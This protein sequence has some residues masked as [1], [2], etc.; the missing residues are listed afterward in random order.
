MSGSEELMVGTPS[1]FLHSILDALPEAI[2]IHATSSKIVWANQKL[3]DIYGRKLSEL[4]GLAC[5]QIF[6]GQEVACPH[7]GVL[8]A[9]SAVQIDGEVRVSGRT[10][11]VTLEPL[12]YEKNN[13]LG[14]TRV[15]RDV[16]SERQTQ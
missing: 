4:E 1:E 3:C 14:F 8:A 12:L 10:F 7:E 9:G 13:P 5:H 6:H 11:S 15:M 2:S 16:T